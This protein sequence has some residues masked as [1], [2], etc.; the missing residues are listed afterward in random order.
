MAIPLDQYLLKYQTAVLAGD[1]DM[2][3]NI[4][5]QIGSRELEKLS[6]FLQ[7]QGYLEEAIKVTKDPMRKL[8]LAI[9]LEDVQQAMDLLDTQGNDNESTKY[10]SQLGE[11]CLKKGDMKTALTCIEKARDFSTMLMLAREAQWGNVAFMAAFMQK[12]LD[13]CMDILT[14]EKRYPEVGIWGGCDT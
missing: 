14:K 11:I 10:W 9:S 4:L 5:P 7:G 2:A 12:D 6:L 1:F 3:N 13:G 8:D